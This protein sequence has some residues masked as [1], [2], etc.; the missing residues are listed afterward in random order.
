MLLYPGEIYRLL[1]ASSL[2]MYGYCLFTGHKNSSHFRK[3]LL[4]YGIFFSDQTQMI[5]KLFLYF[6]SRNLIKLYYLQLIMFAFIMETICLV[7]LTQIFVLFYSNITNL[8]LA[9]SL[10]SEMANLLDAS[11][12]LIEVPKHTHYPHYQ[13]QG[14]HMM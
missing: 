10:C 2:T 11:Q 12:L 7:N 9:T 14:H 1:G 4:L 6:E 3:I 8:H 5:N 13:T